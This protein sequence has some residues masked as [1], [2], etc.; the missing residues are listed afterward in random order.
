MKQPKIIRKIPNENKIVLM[1]S[2]NNYT[3]IHLS[4]GKKLLS[5]YN[6]KFYENCSD[7]QIFM[8]PN[9]S[10]M[11]NKTFVEIINLEEFSVTLNNGRRVP[12]SRR[13]MKAFQA[14]I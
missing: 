5:G 6:L 14:W 3:I 1:E 8:R 4:N 7:N 9:R 12:I 11:I 13:R 2:D 10:I